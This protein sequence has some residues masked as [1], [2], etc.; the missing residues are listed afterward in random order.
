MVDGSDRLAGAV[1][2]K[3]PFSGMGALPIVPEHGQQFGWQH[4]IAIFV[5][6]ALVNPNDHALAI[7]R[8]GLEA[9]GFGDPQTSRV[10]DGQKHAVLKIVHSAQEARDFVLAQNDGKLF[11]LTAGG[12]VVLDSPWPLEGNGVEKPQG[13][14]RD[15][16]RAG[17]E[18]SLLR[19]VEQIGPDLGSAQDVQAIYENT[20]QTGRLARHTHVAYAPKGCGFAYPRSTDDEAGSWTTPVQDGQRHMAPPH[21]LAIELSGQGTGRVGCHQQPSHS[22][23]NV[24]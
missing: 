12:N 7:D 21:R 9:D 5:A 1:T 4:D 10:T 14:D 24:V 16:D 18:M 23:E 17:C 3:Q 19:Q 20:G 13:G 15:N 11:R 6:L 22:E 8:S 2:G